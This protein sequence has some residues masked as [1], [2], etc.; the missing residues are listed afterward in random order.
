MQSVAITFLSADLPLSKSY[1]LQDKVLCKSSYPNVRD[2][3]S[4][5]VSCDTVKDLYNAL[6]EHA[7]QG[8]CLLKGLTN[9][10]LNRESR[11]GATT[12][13]DQTQWMC[14]DLDGAPFKTPQEFIKNLGPKFKDVAYIIQ[15]SA[16]YGL[17]GS[18]KL[19]AHIMMLL[20]KKLPPQH[21]KNWF[22]TQ[23]IT[24]PLRAAVTLTRTGAALHWPLDVSVCQN[25]KLIY[26][27]PPILKDGITSPLKPNE[28]I[29]YVPGAVDRLP[30][31]A[32]SV[33]L[34]LE[35]LKTESREL[36][37]YLRKFY[38]L[39]KLSTAIKF[40][41]EL[42]VQP[43]PGES[44]ITGKK[45]EREF[46]YFNLNNG[47]SWGYWHP[48]ANPEF[49]RNFKDEPCYYTK[50][51]LPGYYKDFKTT[52]RISQSQPTEGGE[53][54]LAFRDKRSAQYYNGTWNETT[55]VLDLHPAK[56][57][58]QLN[59]WMQNHNLP[60]YDVIPIW[61][62]QFNPT[63]TTILSTDTHIL[64]TYVPTPYFRQEFKSN[65]KWPLIERIMRHAVAGGS[66][67]EEKETFEHWLN[68][69]AVIF[70]HKVKPKT[71]WILHGTEGC[72][73]GD[74]ILHFTGGRP[75]TIATAYKKWTNT[76]QLGAGQG[77][78]WDLNLITKTRSV[79]DH[80]TVG[81][82]EIARIVQSGVK[83]LY[84][85]TASNGKN[86]RVTEEHPFM[87]P[88]GS[89]TK[90][91]DLC[92]D[93]EILMRGT[94]RT[95]TNTVH[96]RNKTR[97]TTY[98]IPYHPHAWQHIING[99]NY[100]RIHTARLVYE[101]WINGIS[102]DTLI[103]IVRNFPTQAALLIYLEDD[104]IVHHKDEDPS[105]DDF[106]NLELIDK[107]NHD[108]HH[109]KNVGLGT[110]ATIP[111]RI[112]SII[113]DKVEMTY[114]ITMK[115]PYHNYVAND[116][117]VSN[118]GKGL[119]VSRILT[120]L[121]GHQYVQQ[122]RASELEEKF[123]GWLETALIGFIDEIEVRPNRELIS[124]D[125]RSFI[126]ED[127][128]TIRHMHQAAKQTV[129]YTG[130]ILSS[131]KPTPVSINA[132]DRRYNVG[133]YQNTRLVITNEEVEQG[134]PAELGAFMSYIMTRETSIQKALTALH[135]K[136]HDDLVAS[137]MTSLDVTAEQLV[138]GDL[139][140][141]WDLRVDPRYSGIS[142][143][144]NAPNYAQLF[145]DILYREIV[146]IWKEHK[147]DPEA[148]L[149]VI[150]DPKHAVIKTPTK[151]SREELMIIFQHA[152]GSIPSSPNK[153]TSLLKH[154]KIQLKRMRMREGISFG[155]ETTWQVPWSWLKETYEE[156]TDRIPP[157]VRKLAAVSTS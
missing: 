146:H 119:I 128:V 104:V 115:A 49:I 3:T 6:I 147:G 127:V 103:N 94:A 73:A 68:W 72:L 63:S 102:L 89:F 15:Y 59:H 11:A 142:S 154:K 48:V 129:N 123:T 137:N 132:N 139:S 47:D 125:L 93:D 148:K 65:T 19:S 108:A 78:T 126:T 117:C 85:L 120:P 16:S 134:I 71:A 56:S 37:D 69:L 62:M 66:Q 143:N 111:V 21:I 9:K 22:I 144:T 10:N 131:N 100:K 4:I 55:K 36:R 109:A 1:W 58:L 145:N 88:D 87:R 70:Q 17:L 150:S 105:N 51:L 90:L 40:V 28:R 31:A 91:K 32:L 101:A 57:E 8:H 74:T 157:E 60:P 121:L 95:H 118:T 25:D 97:H 122:K 54:V 2:F 50:E 84:K 140:S 82:H 136:A 34:S 45:T 110:I 124:S 153:F 99:K 79:K 61:D 29:Q 12:S 106:S 76:Y 80:L 30:I 114:D 46:V 77:K 44:I 155:F 92:I 42:E 52:Q 138:D 39:P 35:Q 151:L 43:K 26:I 152:V 116:F 83:Q 96:G 14:F 98:S 113:K 5:T 33:P 64:N 20:D 67:A 107:I 13:D 156:L 133:V 23:N 27:A 135:S 149:L 18:K 141:L 24:Q 75:L 38:K 86:I 130:L 81:Y 112:T 53:I 41:G 7:T